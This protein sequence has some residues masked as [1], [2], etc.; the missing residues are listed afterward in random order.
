MNRQT[1][2]GS[3]ESPASLYGPRFRVE[4]NK[5]AP[6]RANV[7]G[8][9]DWLGVDVTQTTDER[10]I[11]EFPAYVA[12]ADGRIYSCRGADRRQLT[13]I[14]HRTGYHFVTIYRDGR[15]RYRS[16]HSLILA[17]FAGE[18]PSKSHVGRHL[19]GDR[20]DNR[21]ANLAWG[22][23]AENAAD[24]IEHGTATWLSQYGEAATRVKLT[25]AQVLEIERRANS[26]EATTA[27]AHEFNISTRQVRNIRAHRHW[28][29][30]WAVA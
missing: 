23:S 9:A 15:K 4:C 25:E 11:P 12:A 5:A 17:A 10:A 14:L 21:A 18:R 22:T 27:L 20:L 16:V 6:R 2:R 7:R 19:N 28:R 1:R 24:A 8:L 29:H 13:P 3:H 30:L 26:G